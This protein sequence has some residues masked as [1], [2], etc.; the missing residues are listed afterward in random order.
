MGRTEFLTGNG[1]RAS[2]GW[3]SKSKSFHESE[4]ARSSE[5]TE[6]YAQ[7]VFDNADIVREAI[8]RQPPIR[9]TNSMNLSRMAFISQPA[10]HCHSLQIDRVTTVRDNGWQVRALAF[11][12][13]PEPHIP[14]RLHT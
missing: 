12:R 10:C 4:M 8:Y 6:Q 3:Q 7:K 11:W 2:L 5:C 1:L 9:D 14:P 13:C